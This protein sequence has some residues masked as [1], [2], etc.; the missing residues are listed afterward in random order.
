MDG[1]PSLVGL[2]LA[3]A[4]LHGLTACGSS[5]GSPGSPTPPPPPP[6]AQSTV[7][8]LYPSANDGRRLFLLVTAVAGQ[9]VSMPLAFDTGSAGITLYAPDIFPPDLVSAAGFVFPQG[10]HTLSY[11]GITVTDQQAVRRYGSQQFGRDETG[12]LGFAQVTFGDSNGS[13][14][15]Q[16]MP[17]F[18]TYL[19]TDNQT[20]ASVPPGVQRG[21]FGVNDAPNFIAVSGAA[22]LTEYPACTMTSEGSCYVVSV[23]KYLQYPAGL[24]AGFMLANAA[25]QDC[26]IAVTN[27]C[28]PAPILTI[29]LTKD[30][31]ASFASI[32]L[33][34]PPTAN[35][36]PGPAS[37][38]GYPVCQMLIPNIPVTVSGP[39][40]GSFTGN[41][42]FDTGTPY[43]V[44]GGPAGSFPAAIAP[45]STVSIA[46]T[47]GFDYQYT[48]GT[49][50]TGSNA[51]S[52]STLVN[53]SLNETVIGIDYFT[54]NSF[55]IDFTAGTEG[56]K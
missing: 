34:C 1:R 37:I 44:F 41:A 46:V 18:L 21:W 28:Q 30:M 15:T 23:L 24:N 52:Y 36:Y 10:Q 3:C 22:A 7:I 25:L 17:V 40:T 45:G 43:M 50:F 2:V 35:P 47:S 13:L 6:A 5:G 14:Q 29:G 19:I 32:K 53:T 42:L 8:D 51:G 4:A 55:F 54:T 16:T 12:N 33:V 31:E 39:S 27:D 48:A 49:V 11:N 9:S 56:W 38:E 20:G 26:S